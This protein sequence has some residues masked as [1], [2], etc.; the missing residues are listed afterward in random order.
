MLNA[1]Y[2]NSKFHLINNNHD[3][4]IKK[5]TKESCIPTYTRLAIRCTGNKPLIIDHYIQPSI[6]N[7]YL[8]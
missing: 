3:E 6:L 4:I 7:I 1:F 8:F 2:Q 5:R